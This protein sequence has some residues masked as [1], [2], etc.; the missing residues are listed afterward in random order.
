M[1]G[2]SQRARAQG[3]R[4][5]GL[6]SLSA[7]MVLA[8]GIATLVT[9]NMAL[10]AAPLSFAMILNLHNRR[11]MDQL[12]DYYAGLRRNAVQISLRQDLQ[13]IQANVSVHQRNST[14]SE[15][16]QIHQCIH[17]L[18][19]EIK[20]LEAQQESRADAEKRPIFLDQ[21]ELLKEQ[22]QD[23]GQTLMSLMQDLQDISTP[24]VG[25]ATLAA[26]K[27]TLHQYQNSP[28]AMDRSPKIAE[29]VQTWSG[30]VQS[31][32]TQLET[33]TVTLGQQHSADLAVSQGENLKCL[34]GQI[35]SLDQ[36]LAS[37]QKAFSEKLLPFKIDQQNL[38]TSLHQ[39]QK[40]MAS[41]LFDLNSEE[42]STSNS[43]LSQIQ[44]E[45]QIE[46][47]L[48]PLQVQHVSLVNGLELLEMDIQGLVHQARQLKQ[49][50]R[51][52]LGIHQQVQ[53]LT[54]MDRD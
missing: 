2:L 21:I 30:E 33:L 9:H 16:A 15:L 25:L 7:L 6:E 50:H 54:Q 41:V 1:T 20:R 14:E 13:T 52:L 11:Q 3:T 22:A 28:L 32:Q 40:Q 43:A 51:Q 29:L 38:Q 44:I 5:K 42:S 17:E 24:T 27:T 26:L 53:W 19:D 35:A 46:T 12:T 47:A 31:L 4:L 39:L 10:A 8:G 49:I 18:S 45:E 34:H 23:C 36:Q 37:M 48:I